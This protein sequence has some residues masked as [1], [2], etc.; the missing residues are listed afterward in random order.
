[1]K[2]M[3][4]KATLISP[5]IHKDKKTGELR[6]DG[7]MKLIPITI[8]IEPKKESHQIAVEFSLKLLNELGFKIVISEDDFKKL[9]QR[10]FTQVKE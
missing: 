6:D 1:M 10:D 5:I 7:F 9:S 2:Q 4:I 3:E 8:E